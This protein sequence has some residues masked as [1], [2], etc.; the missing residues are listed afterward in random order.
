[1]SV[2]WQIFH[3]SPSAVC[4]KS[5][6]CKVVSHQMMWMSEYSIYILSV[7]LMQ[8]FFSS[9]FVFSFF[10]LILWECF[11]ILLLHAYL[12]MFRGPKNKVIWFYSDWYFTSFKFFR[13]FANI[14][15]RSFNHE[16]QNICTYFH[17]DLKIFSAAYQNKNIFFNPKLGGNLF[18]KYFPVLLKIII[19]IICCCCFLK[20]EFFYFSIYS[21]SKINPNHYHF[22]RYGFRKIITIIVF[23]Y[24][25]YALKCVHQCSC[26]KHQK[27]H[28]NP[29]AGSRFLLESICLNNLL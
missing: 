11:F 26:S 6:F 14:L 15:C 4:K 28:S 1:M 10:S 2:K 21:F 19:Y 18:L 17:Y 3:I 16:S 7:I 5:E 13:G 9:F 12:E 22:K 27:P 24:K 20:L 29:R 25:L 8:L 23:S